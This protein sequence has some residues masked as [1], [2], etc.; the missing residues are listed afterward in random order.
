MPQVLS[1]LVYWYQK[2]KVLSLRTEK[3]NATEEDLLNIF[4]QDLVMSE[5]L[6]K[7]RLLGLLVQKYKY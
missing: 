5:A 2:G 1:L 4:L 6:E 3:T 7:V